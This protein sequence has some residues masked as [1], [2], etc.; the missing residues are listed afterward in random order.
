MRQLLQNLLG[1]ALKYRQRGASRAGRADRCPRRPP[2]ISAQLTVADNG[3][4]FDAQYAERIFGMFERLHGRAE[5]EGSG[6]GL[7]ICRNI[8]ERH[9]GTI[10]RR[11][12]AGRGRDVHRR[13][14]QPANRTPV[15][16]STMSCQGNAIPV[17]RFSS[18]TTMR[19]IGCSPG[20]RSRKP[21]VER[22]RFVEDGEELMDYL[23]RAGTSTPDR[24]ARR[25]ARA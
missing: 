7:A 2:A 18:P 1:N 23:R 21:T 14:A 19:T 15:D 20:R 24:T 17:D 22:V 25:R 12:H 16:L 3:I 4:G 10:S 13:A 11:R 6:I 8:V 5:Y 9:G